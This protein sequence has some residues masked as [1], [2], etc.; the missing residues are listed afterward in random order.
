MRAHAKTILRAAAAASSLTLFAPAAQ[1]ATRYVSPTGSDAVNCLSQAAPCQSLQRA[2]N[3]AVTGD[4]LAVAEGTY[5]YTAA[6]EVCSAP[7]GETGVVCILNKVL[8]LQGGYPTGNWVTPD[9]TA[10]PSIISGQN[11]RR[12][13]L[14]ERT[15]PAEPAAGLTLDG[16]QIRNCSGGPATV[17]DLITA[18]GGGLSA[19]A[20]TVGSAIAVTI[21]RVVFD[22]NIVIGGNG[23]AGAGA[24]GAVALRNVNPGVLDQLT[25]TNNTARGGTGSPRGGYGIGGGVFTFQSVVTGTNLTFTGNRAEG[26]NTTGDGTDG[27]GEEGDAQGGGFAA[28]QGSTVTLTGIVANGNAADGGNAA[29]H[30]GGGFGGALYTELATFTVSQAELFSNTVSGGNA[31]NGGTSG[32][33]GAGGA[34]MSF[35]ANLNLSRTRMI[36][37]QSLAGTGTA[38]AG[39]AGGGAVY[40]T[41]AV[42]ID[43]TSQLTNV[44]IGD[45]AVSGLFGGGGALFLQN[46]NNTLTHVTLA[47]NQLQTAT[48][49]G[50][51]MVLV[52]ANVTATMNHCIIA[53][54]TAAPVRPALYNQTGGS[55]TLN[56]GLFAGNNDDTNNGDGGAGTYSGLATMTSAGSAGFRSPARPTTTTTCSPP[57]PPSTSPWAARSPSTSTGRSVPAHATSGPTSSMC[58]SSATGSSRATPRPGPS[59]RLDGRP[60]PAG[61]GDLGRR[62]HL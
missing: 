34:V 51:A 62:Q 59:R 52:G 57:R 40:I 35:R 23:G 50:L 41:G 49:T 39:D 20:P 6:Q 38:N 56:R 36:L 1:A 10:H 54:H 45:N 47:R 37:N 11:T 30:P 61:R 60:R 44:I 14:V 28:Q 4:T 25:F 9:P 13:I 32:G 19:L 26:G 5:V 53:D 7:V 46:S 33:L 17:G 21:R 8:T 15:G 2:V 42:P 58:S 43:T 22:S 48:L 3:Q 27:V 55:Y 29:V 12:G 24:G 16:F 31:S 18:F